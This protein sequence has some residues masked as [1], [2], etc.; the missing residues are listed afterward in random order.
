MIASKTA[1]L[2]FFSSNIK[3]KLCL[4]EVVLASHADFL[5]ISKGVGGVSFWPRNTINP[6]RNAEKYN[7][8]KAIAKTILEN[9]LNFDIAF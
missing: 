7:N 3:I 5:D 2:F 8:A 6:F 1:L 4:K 9:L